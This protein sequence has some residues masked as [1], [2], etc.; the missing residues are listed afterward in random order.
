MRI[1][2]LTFTGADDLTSITSMIEVCKEYPF[3]EFGILTKRKFWG[4]HEN[5]IVEWDKPR[6]PSIKWIRELVGRFAIEGLRNNLSLHICPPLTYE[7]FEDMNMLS[8]FD[9]FGR[10]QLNSAPSKFDFDE[11]VYEYSISMKRQIIIQLNG[12]KPEIFLQNNFLANNVWDDITPVVGLFDGS[13][14]R[15]VL[16]KEWR[17]PLVNASNILVGYAGGLNPD[18]LAEE[19]GKIRLVAGDNPIWLDMETGVR[20]KINSTLHE[21]VFSIIKVRTCCKIVKELL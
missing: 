19:I 11:R 1:I 12:T 5:N 2:K 13:G 3:A 8:Q 14:G 4:E 21:E 16:A 10:V 7:I 6:Y 18:N 20:T 15:G 17:S 9:G